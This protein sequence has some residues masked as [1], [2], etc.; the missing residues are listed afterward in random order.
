M[1]DTERRSATV[2]KSSAMDAVA[3][4]AETIVGSGICGGSTAGSGSVKRIDTLYFEQTIQALIAAN[5]KFASARERVVRQTKELTD[6]W[7]GHGSA[8]FREIFWRLKRE[9]DDEEELLCAMKEDLE[10]ILE[11]YQSWD[12]SM[13]SAISGNESK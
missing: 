8:K 7:Q 11:T 10:Q 6:S 13:A 2:I 9:L 5:N 3:H 12:Q 1:T 4:A